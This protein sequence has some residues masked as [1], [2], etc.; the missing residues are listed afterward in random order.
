[1]L[2]QLMAAVTS[3]RAAVLLAPLGPGWKLWQ[4]WGQGPELLENVFAR[5]PGLPVGSRGSITSLYT[6]VTC[7]L[8]PQPRVFLAQGPSP[9]QSW[10]SP[11][12]LP[13]GVGPLA[14]SP[15]GV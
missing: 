4:D 13:W 3:H 10:E 12:Q 14:L 8:A 6:S 15:A 2:M 9:A 1:M 11:T 5:C 7:R